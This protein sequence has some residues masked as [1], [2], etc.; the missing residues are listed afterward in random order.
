MP[1]ADSSASNCALLTKSRRTWSCRSAFQSI[2]MALRMWFLSY[3]VVSS[4]TSTR[5]TLGSSRWASTQSASTS[6]SVRLMSCFLPKGRAWNKRSVRGRDGSAQEQVH[7][8]AEA[9]PERGVE[10]RG[11]EGGGD[12]EDRQEGDEGDRDQGHQGEAEADRL[13]EAQGAYVLQLRGRLQA[14]PD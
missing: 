1:L 3:A 7:L 8:A 9:V 5:T 14:R 12:R 10:E 13:R 6:A 2:L 4:S 11:D